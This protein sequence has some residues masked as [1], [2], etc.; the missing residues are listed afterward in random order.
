MQEQFASKIWPG[1]LLPALLG[2]K[3]TGTI[4]TNNKEKMGEPVGE[5]M[6]EQMGARMGEP[7]SQASKQAGQQANKQSCQVS[8]YAG[9]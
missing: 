3:M 1:K 7:E 5:T 4:A 9:H 6:G 2:T 8:F